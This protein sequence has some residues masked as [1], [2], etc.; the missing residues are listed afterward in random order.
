M[1]GYTD[2]HS[3]SGMTRELPTKF[4]GKLPGNFQRKARDDTTFLSVLLWLG[5]AKMP[6]AILLVQEHSERMSTGS[7]LVANV[8]KWDVWEGHVHHRFAVRSP[9]QTPQNVLS[10][11]R[12]PGCDRIEPP[13]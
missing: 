6:A 3:F 4:M 8:F 13:F 10:R 5:A 2:S 12:M 9:P 7:F 1:I 11:F